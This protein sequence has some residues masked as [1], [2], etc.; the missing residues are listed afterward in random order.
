MQTWL[1]TSA[2]GCCWCTERKLKRSTERK[3][4][5]GRNRGKGGQKRRKR[6]REMKRREGEIKRKRVTVFFFPKLSSKLMRSFSY[7][8]PEPANISSRVHTHIHTERLPP[9]H[10]HRNPFSPIHFCT[11]TLSMGVRYTL[12]CCNRN[13]ACWSQRLVVRTVRVAKTKRET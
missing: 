13:L 10:W 2:E 4:R 7:T 11:H 5:M 8:H 1:D 3:R 12:C 6:E 9:L